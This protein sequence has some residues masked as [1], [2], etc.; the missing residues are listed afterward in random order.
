MIAL[1]AAEDLVA[2]RL[3]D[4]DLILAGELQRGLDGFR[5]SGGEVD[6]TVAEILSGEGEKFS[7]ILFGDRGGELAGVDEF[8]LGGLL[9][10]GGGNFGDAVSDE[11]DGGGA[12]E[13]EIAVAG[14][15]PEVNTLATDGGGESL[16]EGSAE[17]GGAGDG[18]SGHGGIIAFEVE[19]QD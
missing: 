9:G 3:S 15:V 10:H 17:D 8:K 5:A 12:G 18:R 16:A 7:G 13:I 14:G 4:F 19:C 1:L 6:G 11:V 2:G